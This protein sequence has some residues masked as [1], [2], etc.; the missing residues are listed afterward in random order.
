MM[1]SEKLSHACAVADPNASHCIGSRWGLENQY[2]A[3]LNTVNG[4]LRP[5]RGC[6]ARQR[7]T[8]EPCTAVVGSILAR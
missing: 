6:S 1:H 7:A 5:A 3:V 8:A 4:P 2:T